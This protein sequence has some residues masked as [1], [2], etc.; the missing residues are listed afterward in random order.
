[1]T[2]EATTGTRESSRDERVGPAGEEPGEEGPFRVQGGLPIT[3]AEFALLR[4]LIHRRSGIL[5]GDGKASLLVSRLGRRLRSL[6]LSRFMDYYHFLMAGEDPEEMGRALDLITTNETRFFREPRQFEYLQN[7]VVPQWRRQRERGRRGSRIR[8]WSAACSTGEEAYS[9][10]MTLLWDLPAEEGWKVDVLGTD[11]SSKALCRAV[12]GVWSADQAPHVPQ[13]LRKKYLRRGTGSMK[14]HMTASE[15]VRSVVRFGRLNLSQ[16][17]DASLGSFDLILCRN[18]LIYFDD[19]GR[20]GTLERLTQ[21]LE[22]NGYLLLGH[23]ERPGETL[24]HLERVDTMVFRRP[25][26]ESRIGVSDR[27]D[28][29]GTLGGTS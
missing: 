25:R 28:D 11:L 19:R 16:E 23:A 24:T 9:L 12:E 15:E 20:A 1:M 6:G 18:V 27:D 7:H 21:R 29:R 17:V 26:G 14:G 10:A 13:E 3:D 4:D 2:S 22:P 8:A 5:L